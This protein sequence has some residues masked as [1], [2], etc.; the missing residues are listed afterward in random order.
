MPI[1][2]NFHILLATF[3][4]IFG[5]NILVQCPV[6]VPVCCMS[7]VSQKIHIKWSPNGIKTDGDFFGEYMWFWGRR[8]NTRQACPGPSWPPRKAVDALLLPNSELR[9]S[10]YKRNGE[11]AE[12][13]NAE[14]KRDRE[15]DPISEGLSPLPHHGSQGPEGKP[16]SHLGR[17]SRKKNKK[18]GSPPSLPVAPEH[19]CGHHHHR[20]LHQQLHRH[21]H[22]LFPPLCSGVT[23]LLPTIIST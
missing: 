5:T 7:F 12:S 19:R 10:L 23:P 13:E 4:T 8:T 1:L 9:I 11:R 6:S 22:Q 2:Y 18:G 17:R 20:N 16:F 3:Y 21:H 15:T 14:T